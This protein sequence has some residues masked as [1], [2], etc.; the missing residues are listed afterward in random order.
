MSQYETKKTFTY[1]QALS[2]F[3]LVQKMTTEAVQEVNVLGA[4]IYALRD[5]EET[6]KRYEKKQALI[7][8]RWVQKIEALGCDVKGLWLVD[9]DNGEGYY[10]WQ[11]PEANLDYFHGYAEGFSGRAKLF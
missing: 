3:P 9:F 4:Q 8:N 5:D 2:L 7:V 6:K 1:E 11:Y 10:C